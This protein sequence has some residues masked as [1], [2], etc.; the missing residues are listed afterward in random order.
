MCL[1]AVSLVLVSQGGLGPLQGVG[2]AE[3]GLKRRGRNPPWSGS[4][5]WKNLGQ[6]TRTI[7]PTRAG[8]QHV[9]LSHIP[10][11]PVGKRACEPGP[12]SGHLNGLVTSVPWMAPKPSIMGV[13]GG[14]GMEVHQERTGGG[15]RGVQRAPCSLF[16]RQGGRQRK[17]P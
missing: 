12:G 1:A 9:M 11:Q 13:G 14:D 8:F 15:P 3:C 10:G 2:G 17:C 6:L 7:S 16:T 4:K 5:I